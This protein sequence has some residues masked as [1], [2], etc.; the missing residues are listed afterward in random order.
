MKKMRKLV[1]VGIAMTLMMLVA[2]CVR[3]SRKAYK[4]IVLSSSGKSYEKL[5]GFVQPGQINDKIRKMV[6]KYKGG[7]G[8]ENVAIQK[9]SGV[10]ETYLAPVFIDGG[11]C[12]EIGSE[13]W[14]ID[15]THKRNRAALH[16]GIDIPQPRGTPIRAI[17]DGVVVGKFESKLYSGICGLNQARSYDI[18]NKLGGQE[19]EMVA[20]LS[21]VHP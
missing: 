11:D 12:P 2:G 19:S 17:A 21:S 18:C 4:G 6:G 9:A 3:E 1:N 5:D 15:Y 14:A 8:T 13:K 10:I 7:G 20:K 16:K